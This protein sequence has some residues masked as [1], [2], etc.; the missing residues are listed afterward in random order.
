MLSAIFNIR[1]LQNI[2]LFFVTKYSVA[3]YLSRLSVHFMRDARDDT[4]IIRYLFISGVEYYAVLSSVGQE[5]DF[6]EQKL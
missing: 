1:A 3:K 5:E 4:A 6:P 2:G